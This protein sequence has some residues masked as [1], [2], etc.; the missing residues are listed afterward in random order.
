M[1]SA[2]F[3]EATIG[4]SGIAPLE[5]YF[6]DGPH[7][8]AGAYGALDNTYYRFSRAYPDPLDPDYHPVGPDRVFDVTN[9]PSLRFAIDMTDLDGARIVITTGQSGNPFDRHYNDMIDPWRNGETVPLPF[10]QAAI[11]AAAAET[12]VLQP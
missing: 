1:H 6:N 8:V 11:D 12:L 10:T 7:A 3:Q 5:W 4:S 2:T 9:L